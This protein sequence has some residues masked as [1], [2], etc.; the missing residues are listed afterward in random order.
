MSYDWDAH[1]KKL[2]ED[3]RDL[4]K[5]VAELALVLHSVFEGRAWGTGELDCWCETVDEEDTVTYHPSPETNC[6]RLAAALLL[7]KP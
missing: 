3:L 7:E 6:W 2:E 5:E 4:E 1:W